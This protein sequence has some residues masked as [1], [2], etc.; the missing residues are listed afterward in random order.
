M[1]KLGVDDVCGVFA[2]HGSAGALGTLLI[3]V[4]AVA[5]FSATQMIMQAAGI[6][7][8][9]LWIVVT[10]YTVFKVADVVVGLRVTDEEEID[11]LDRREHGVSAYPEF[12]GSIGPSNPGITEGGDR[13]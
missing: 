5:G 7:V 12:T 3:P 2:V 8:I 4:F 10:T 9:A 1:D 13:L 6:L 11:G